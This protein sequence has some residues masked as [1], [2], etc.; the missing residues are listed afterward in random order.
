MADMKR[1]NR[2]VDI[3]GLLDR[4]TRVTAMSLADRF[5]VA[6]RTV[7]RDLQ[8]LAHDFPLHFNKETGSYCFTEGFSLSR[9]DLSPAEVKALL[10]AKA[11]LSRLDQGMAKAH[12]VLMK[13]IT[14]ASG[15]KTGR[16]FTSAKFCYWFDIDPV[17]D[18]SAVQ[19]QF[20][21][22]QKALDDCISLDITYKAMHSQ[23]I[24]K[25]RINPYGLFY[26]NGVW[27]TLAYCNLKEDVREF[28]LDCIQNIA[29][30]D[31]RYTIPA[32][33]SMEDYFK[34]GWHIIRY[35]KPVELTLRF[36][37]GMA[38]WIIRRKWHPSQKIEHKKDGSILFKVTLEGTEEIRRWIYNW[39]PDCEVLSPPEFRKEV[40]AE[41]RAMAEIYS[42]RR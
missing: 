39:G 12:D 3:L 20:D 31:K 17:E 18:S 6:E 2:L 28:A 29:I 24:T 26:S 15:P 5:G 19:R 13:K 33:F 22:I 27:Y 34:S 37:P 11:V 38:R 10:A 4:R 23:E 41:L 1:V 35:G 7:Y 9:I 30:T 36:S 40:A 42:R 21:A 25:R 8:V 32:G 14:S 16:R